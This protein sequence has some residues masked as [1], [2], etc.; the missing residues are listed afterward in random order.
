MQETPGTSETITDLSGALKNDP[1]ISVTDIVVL[2]VSISTVDGGVVSKTVMQNK[3]VVVTTRPTI[4]LALGYALRKGQERT[5]WLAPFGIFVSLI[6]TLMT[7]ESFRKGMF[8]SS[9]TW[10]G[11][12]VAFCLIFLF[13]AIW[14]AVTGLRSMRK[15]LVIAK[16]L[17]IVE[18]TERLEETLE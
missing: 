2:D 3:D 14:Q 4:L 17:K 10:R 16:A 13:L 18:R 12:F 15:S 5:I 11:F 1:A 6:A 8:F 7:A 9:E